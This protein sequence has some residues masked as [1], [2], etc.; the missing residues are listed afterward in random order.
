MTDPRF[1]PDGS[2]IAYQSMERDGYESDLD[3]LFVYNIKSGTRSWISKG[4]NDDVANIT[5]EDNKTCFLL[6]LTLAQP[7]SL[8]PAL[9]ERCIKGN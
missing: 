7:R 3:R 8:K 4:W 1:L 9:R 2:M 5:W 6:V